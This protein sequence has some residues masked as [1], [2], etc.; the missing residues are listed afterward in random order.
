M[1]FQIRDEPYD[2]PVAQSLIV[3]LQA[4]YVTRYGG[5][6][7][8]P[9]DPVQFAP[10]DGVFVIGEVDGVAVAMG[11]LRPG[12]DGAVEIKR[13]YVLPEARGKGFARRVLSALEDRARSL[14]ATQVVL[15]TGQRQP[16]AIK[17]YESSGY[18]RIAGFGHYRDAPL[19]LSFAKQLH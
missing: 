15:E 13:M 4:E 9:V 11:G 19:S 12:L 6:D 10:P 16:E 18:H 5:P 1:T 2:G 17:L 3:A 8:T 7:A 14:G